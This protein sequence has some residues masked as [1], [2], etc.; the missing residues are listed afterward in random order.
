MPPVLVDID[1]SFY[2][3]CAVTCLLAMQRCQFTRIPSTLAIAVGVSDDADRR[4]F[5][6]PDPPS[7]AIWSSPDRPT[8]QTIDGAGPDL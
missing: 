4:L 5:T 6:G 1:I 8:S 2:S 3:G 7:S